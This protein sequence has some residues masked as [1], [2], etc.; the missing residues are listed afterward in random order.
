MKPSLDELDNVERYLNREKRPS[1]W[2]GIRGY[3]PEREVD[4]EF[5]WFVKKESTRSA[6]KRSDDWGLR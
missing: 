5:L 4:G 1:K 3:K 6:E 2:L